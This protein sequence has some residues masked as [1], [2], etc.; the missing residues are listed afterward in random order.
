MFQSAHCCHHLFHH[1]L[2]NPIQPRVKLKKSQTKHEI[3]HSSSQTTMYLKLFFHLQIYHPKHPKKPIA[4]HTLLSFF[5]SFIIFFSFIPSL[6]HPIPSFNQVLSEYLFKMNCQDGI[7]LFSKEIEKAFQ[8]SL[9]RCNVQYL[10]QAR[11]RLNPK[12]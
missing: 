2:K 7:T 11:P 3:N 5:F 12:E 9:T 10:P 6:L 4:P 1:F 8:W